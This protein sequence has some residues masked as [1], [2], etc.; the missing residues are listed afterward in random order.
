MS[1]SL[2]MILC[3]VQYFFL[4]AQSRVLQLLDSLL[5]V[6]ADSR[7]LSRDAEAAVSVK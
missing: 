1:S 2:Q 3:H 5:A 7:L 6:G 4:A